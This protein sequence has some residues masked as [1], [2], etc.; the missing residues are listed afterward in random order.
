MYR[1]VFWT[2]WEKARVGWFE[3]VALKH[4][5]YHMGNR[6]PVQVWCMRLGTQGRCTG[7]TLRDGIGREVGGGFRMGDTCTPRADSRDLIH[8]NHTRVISLQLN[9]LQKKKNP[10]AKAGDPRFNPW[11]GKI[12]WRRK[13]QPTAVFFPEKSR[14]QRS[15]G[16]G[17][18]LGH[19][20]VGYDLVTNN[21]S[22]D[23][24]I[25]PG[26]PNIS[27]FSLPLH[28]VSFFFNH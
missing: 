2:L 21:N 10:P 4:V 24:W 3:R 5:Y 22:P 15:L 11:D 25:H 27:S 12:P 1:I 20:R 16:D 9:N 23:I 19:K 7:M 6:L 28:T 18:P 17:S 13:W 8:K 26:L 14:G